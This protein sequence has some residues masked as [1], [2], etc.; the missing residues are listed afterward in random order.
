MY[1]CNQITKNMVKR[2]IIMIVILE[3][4]C[5]GLP[6]CAEQ[7]C[8]LGLCQPNGLIFNPHFQPDGLIRLVQYD[9]TSLSFFLCHNDSR[10][11]DVPILVCE[12]ATK[13]L[14]GKDFYII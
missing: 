11:V 7:L 2:T 14:Y 8:H 1:I 3:M 13:F 4:F 10:I 9:F 5:N 6:T 12:G